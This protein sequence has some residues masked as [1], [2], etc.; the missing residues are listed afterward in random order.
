[1]YNSSNLYNTVLIRCSCTEL[2]ENTSK[3][4]RINFRILGLRPMTTPT[5]NNQ[6][7]LFLRKIPLC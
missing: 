5:P 4:W 2:D 3:E 1:M 7:I 6:C